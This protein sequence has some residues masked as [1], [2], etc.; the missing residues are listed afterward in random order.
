[1]VL[2]GIWEVRLG[3]VL[4]LDDISTYVTLKLANN[5]WIDANRLG[6]LGASYGGFMIYWINGHTNRFKCLVNHD[7][8]FNQI[9]MGYTTEELFFT[10]WEFKGTP[11][12]SD[13]YEK[14]APHKFVDKWQTPTL[15]QW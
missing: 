8:V 2:A 15:D 3:V 10:E 14:F 12:S 7:G 5:S 4:T 9:S 11:W 6:S 1:M 13:L